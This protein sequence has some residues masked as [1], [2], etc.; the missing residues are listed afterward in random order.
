MPSAG[1]P[2]SWIPILST[3]G[4]RARR[5]CGGPALAG[6]TYNGRVG[7]TLHGKWHVLRDILQ[8]H[9]RLLVA[10]SAGCDSTFLLAAAR[11]SLGKN[12]V[13][14]VTAVSASLPSKERNRAEA[15]ASFLDVDYQMLNTDE[16]E[17]PSYAANPSNRC[18]FC[19]NELFGKL[20]PIA[21]GGGWVLAD[22]FNASDRSDYRPGYQAAQSWHVVHP[23]DEA[24]LEKREIRALSRWMRLP[25]W[26]K[27]A[28]PCLS[29]RVPYGTPVLQETLRQIERAEDALHAEGFSV[30]RVR[31]HGRLARIEVPLVDSRRLLEPERW[32]RIVG[33]LRTCGYES[34]EADP[35]G[36]QSG[37]LNE[38]LS[39]DKNAV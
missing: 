15:L 3:T 8:T 18:F 21:Q 1:I 29:S 31:H 26:N 4:G 20:A 6:M 37:R 22:G 28:S 30:V 9:K 24:G 23:L 5:V 12:N 7:Q 25:T 10:F 34:V 16:L 27:P 11:R 36:F 17:N 19:K 35:R 2:A 13:L 32:A 39:Q 38:G 33:Q 14:A